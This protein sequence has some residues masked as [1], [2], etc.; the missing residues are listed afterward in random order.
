MFV[1]TLQS[2]NIINCNTHQ[3]TDTISVTLIQVA[4]LSMEGCFLQGDREW[5]GVQWHTRVHC[6]V[7]LQ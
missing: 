1:A 3:G 2:H 7:F 4:F 6:H 5:K